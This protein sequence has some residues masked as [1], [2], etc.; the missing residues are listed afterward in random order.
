MARSVALLLTVLTGF[1]GLVYEV[2]W[3]RYLASLL[4]SDAEAS[5]ALLGIFL[6]GLSLG[7]AIFGAL[8][9]RLVAR[10]A[11]AGRPPR[12]I[13]V[14]GLVEAGIGVYALAFPM[15]YRLVLGLSLR[16]HAGAEGAGFLLDVGLTA[17]LVGP[18]TLLMG[19]TIPLLT[20]GLARSLGDAT[21]IHSLVYA[22]NTAGAFVGA[23]A[24]GFVLIPWLGLERVMFAM[25]ALN[26]LAGS[27]FLLLE[28]GRR[29]ASPGGEGA[30]SAPE[31]VVGLPPGFSLYASVALL[32]GFAA[33]CLQTVLL[34]LG[35]LALG[36]S[37]LT[38]SMVV[39]CFVLCIAIGSFVVSA[40]P[41]IAPGWIVASQWSLVALLALL[42]TQL[43]DAG[44]WIYRLRRLFPNADSAFEPFHLA[45][46][47]CTLAVLALPIA[48][49]GATLPLLFD[50]LRR[51][52]GDLGHVA[53]RLYS[54]NTVGSL[55][56]ALV[57]GH[58]LLL[59]LDLHHVYRIALAALVIAAAMLTVRLL[60][61]AP[62]R[63]AGVAL[64]ALVGIGLLSPW[65]PLRLSAG[66]FRLRVLPSYA[67]EGPDA[68]FAL[69]AKQTKV[70][71]HDDDP[72]TTV[73]V[74]ERMTPDYGRS[75]SI[76]TNGKSDGATGADAAT[77]VL[78]AALPALYVDRIESAFV[79]G[80]GTGMTIGELATMPSV[81]RVDVAEISRGVVRASPLFDEANLGALRSPKVRLHAG[82]AY[83]LLLRSP[84]RY[85]AIISEP[86]NPWTTGVEMLFAREFLEAAK[87]RLR[88]GGAFVQWMHVYE[89][90][91]QTIALV[92][93]T[94]DAVFD[95]VVVW[96]GTG[97]D[98]LLIGLDDPE[99]ALDLDLI[100]ERA[101][102]PTVRAALIR[103]GVASLPALLAHELLPL[104]V[105]RSAGLE[106]DLHTLGHPLLGHRAARA[107]FR[108]A[109]A[110][111]P[112]TVTPAAAEVGARNSLLRRLAARS[113]GRLSEADRAQAARE[114]CRWRPIEC[115]T[116]L[117]SWQHDE[118][119]SEALGFALG[120]ARDHAVDRT[121]LEPQ[122][123]GSLGR[124]FGA[125]DG[126]PVEAGS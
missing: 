116:F 7:Y 25:G 15:L 80:L 3:Q 73:Q 75:L 119:G 102:S 86:S 26:L 35:G 55:L 114:L 83:R 115:A 12:L 13:G 99:R 59:F 105:V 110:E 97:V 124:L 69:F 121:L 19:G 64:V 34:R 85:D 91:A 21:R 78:A 39:A 37:Q 48:L 92:L 101:A 111:L 38:F 24:A 117:A 18:S 49:S 89:T 90:D 81:Q 79:I 36:A 17:L 56:G 28:V 72:T 103:G 14:Y 123:L 108:G 66:L 96:Y 29:A 87:S 20:Q 71:F 88:P 76:L 113:G 65:E 118:P 53:G 60:G 100:E 23:L 126:A 41:R 95:H 77:M 22:F 11:A 82:D 98:L 45:V 54:W 16:L 109:S 51:E 6:G 93:R 122:R 47:G 46:F 61:L 32:A 104:G 70:L 58:F 107:F 8:T 33:M 50:R 63:A 10:A 112:N 62:L 5:A 1:S 125:G 9:R 120:D 30:A 84:D 94:Y 27:V 57:G 4:G 43:P 68:F 2:T 44:Y 52:V 42:Y 40:L 74:R 67:L 106:G 31:A